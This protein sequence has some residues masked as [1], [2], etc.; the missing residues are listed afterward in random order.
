MEVVELTLCAIKLDFD[1]DVATE[2]FSR[3]RMELI[4]FVS[5]YSPQSRHG[6]CCTTV[7]ALF[8][9]KYKRPF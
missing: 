8:L 5:Q 6:F 3:F 1:S 7:P 9:L 2:A 4:I